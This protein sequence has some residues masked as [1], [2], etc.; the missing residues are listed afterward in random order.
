MNNLNTFQAFGF[1]FSKLINDINI[2]LLSVKLNDLHI[3]KNLYGVK[4]VTT[5]KHLQEKK[6]CYYIYHYQMEEMQ[7][8]LNVMKVASNVIYLDYDCNCE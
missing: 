3:I 5:P 2:L 6:T 8:S 1:N 7:S 4:N